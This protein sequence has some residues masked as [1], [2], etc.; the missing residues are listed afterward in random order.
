MA[1][2]AKFFTRIWIESIRQLNV[3]KSIRIKVAE[4]AVMRIAKERIKVNVMMG[5]NWNKL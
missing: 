5:F 3:A 4:T 1:A 2:F